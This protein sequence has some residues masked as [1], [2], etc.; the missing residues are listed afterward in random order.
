MLDK[1]TNTKRIRRTPEEARSL[2]LEVAARRLGEMGLEG[3]NISG[4]AQEAGMSHATVIH[5]FGSTG[6]MREELLKKMTTEL[7]VDVMDALQAHESTEGVLD[8][9]FSKLSQGGHGRLVAWLLLDQSTGEWSAQSPDTKQMFKSIIDTIAE[10]AGSE[11]DAKQQV[12]L[13]ALAA[14]GLGIAGDRL[15]EL[16]GLDQADQQEFPHWLAEH[17]G[18]L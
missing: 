15:A 10:E 12:F 8:R 1:G 4:V 11:R 3:L 7:L 14:M 2:I 13:V 5:H 6:A 16:I 9:L 17:F 18:S